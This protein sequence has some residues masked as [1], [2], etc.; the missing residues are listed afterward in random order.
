MEGKITIVIPV[1]NGNNYLAEALGS[2]AAQG[3]DVETIVVDDGSTDDTV[4]IARSFGCKVISHPVSV[5]QVVA[6][7]TGLEAATGA[8]VM[9]L[10][11]DDRIRDGAL[12]KMYE[13]LSSDPSVYAVEAKVKDFLSPEISEMKGTLI[14]PEAYYGLFTGAILIRREAFGKTGLFP[15][16][17]HD[18]EIIHWHTRMEQC[19]L[20]IKKI[21]LVSTDRRI[22][23]TNFGK[24]HKGKEYKDFAAILRQR[25]MAAKNK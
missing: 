10:D 13:E 16:N 14:R 2:I 24:T 19:G 5:G 9:F 23:N 15:V 7:N 17:I 12:R 1:K 8:F 3:M 22:H 4:E 20:P 11:H 18:G 21:D 6:K 25:L